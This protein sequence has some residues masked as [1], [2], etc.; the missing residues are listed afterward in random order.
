MTRKQTLLLII[1]VGLLVLFLRPDV[2]G[3]LFALVFLGMIP[4][5]S[6]AVPSLFMFIAYTVIAIATIHWLAHQPLYVGNLSRQEKTA[7]S[8][9]RKKVL[10]KKKTTSSKRR[11]RKTARA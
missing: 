1:G 10:N 5:T 11:V 3:A 7:R 2:S 8:I 6:Y 9:A 4:G